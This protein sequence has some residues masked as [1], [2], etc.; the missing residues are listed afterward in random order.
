MPTQRGLERLASK[1]LTPPLFRTVKRFG[2]GHCVSEKLRSNLSG[3]RLNAVDFLS[4]EGYLVL[5]ALNA[6]EAVRILEVHQDISL[7]FA[8][9][10]MPGSMDGGWW[11]WSIGVGRRSC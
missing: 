2:N 11:I 4:D 6:D 8:D 9:V 10:N 3:L 7:V 1:M 5:E